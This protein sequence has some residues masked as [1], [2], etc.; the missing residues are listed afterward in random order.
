MTNE[1]HF[2]KTIS[3]WEFDYDLFTNLLRIIVICDFS[4]SSFNLRRGILTLLTKY[5]SELGNYLYHCHIKLKIFFW[6][7]LLENLILAKYLIT[8][9]ATLKKPGKVYPL[10][11]WTVKV[12]M[13]HQYW[14]FMKE[15]LLHILFL[16][17][18]SLM[19]F[20]KQLLIKS[21]PKQSFL[22]NLFQISYHLIS[23]TPF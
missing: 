2:L 22:A 17:L 10:Y 14:S 12:I 8:V 21:N 7:K 15:I 13:T 6:T 11:L 16:L 9:A 5:V 3:Q 23:M 4:P 19:T 18:M 20:S 1:K